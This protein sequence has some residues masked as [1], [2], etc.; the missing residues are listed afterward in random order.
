MSKYQR[1]SKGKEIRPTFFVFCEGESEEAYISFI[2]NKYRVPIQIRSKVAKNKINQKYVTGILKP[3]QKQEK[4]KYFLLYDLDVPEMLEKLQSIN[5]TIL[6]VSDP[7]IEL[8]YI[9]HT[10]NHSGEATSAQCITQ[11]EGICKGYRKGTICDK[12]KQEL[13]S[14]EENACKWA[15]KLAL[16]NNFD[17][18]STSVYILIDELKKVTT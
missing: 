12:L 5:D 16:R 18:P 4:D 14:G 10:C 17:N 15:K 9:L 6:L 2:R 1:Q 13:I 8:W 3:F 11:L 7:C